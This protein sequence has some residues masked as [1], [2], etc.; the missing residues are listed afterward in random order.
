[1]AIDASLDKSA[2]LVTKLERHSSGGA[3]DEELKHVAL[4]TRCQADEYIRVASPGAK[5]AKPGAQGRHDTGLV[6]PSYC[7]GQGVG[8][9]VWA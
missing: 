5:E 8:L 6:L 9:N 3:R 2:I 1:M 4:A 7:C